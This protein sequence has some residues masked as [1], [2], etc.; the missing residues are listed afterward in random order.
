MLGYGIGKSYVF[1]LK[2][3]KNCVSLY[4]DDA[5]QIDDPTYRVYFWADDGGAK[6]EWAL[7]GAD[8][9][10]NGEEWPSWAQRVYR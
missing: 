4:V 5:S 8:L 3:Q 6:E 1:H 9:D 10:A 7:S 2:A